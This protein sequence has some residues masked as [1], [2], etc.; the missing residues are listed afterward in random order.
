MEQKYTFFWNGP[1]SN[2]YHSPF[3]YKGKQF[4]NSE[5]A[6]MVCKAELFG[7]DLIAKQ[8]IKNQNPRTVKALGRKVNNFDG[9]IWDKH[10][11]NIMFEVCLEKFKQH[12]GCK[13]AILEAN[14]KFV[15][16]SPYDKVWGIE[17][18]EGEL[19]IEDPKNWKGQNLL[20]LVL[21]KVKENI[22]ALQ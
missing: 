1:F 15:E 5:A 7:D 11:F 3:E 13:K 21:D 17:M 10:K 19:G 12:E 6:F 18:A 8:I 9:E 2:W 14:G 4:E 22:L 20:G 16:A